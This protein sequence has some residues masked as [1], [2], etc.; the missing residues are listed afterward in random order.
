MSNEKE[1]SES[2][3]VVQDVP[4]T[5]N[6]G[7]WTAAWTVTVEKMSGAE[8]VSWD[9]D[10]LVIQ[11]PEGCTKLRIHNNNTSRNVQVEMPPSETNAL[12]GNPYSDLPLSASENSDRERCRLIL[13]NGERCSRMAAYWVGTREDDAKHVCVHHVNDVLRQG[14]VI[15]HHPGGWPADASASPREEVPPMRVFIGDEEL[16]IIAEKSYCGPWQIDYASR[17]GPHVEG[18]LS[19]QGFFKVK[20][21]DAGDGSLVGKYVRIHVKDGKPDGH[22]VA[23][24]RDYCHEKYHSGGFYSFISEGAPLED[25]DPARGALSLFRLAVEEAQALVAE[26]SETRWAEQEVC[27]RKHH[28]KDGP[29]RGDYCHCDCERCRKQCAEGC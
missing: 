27:P 24:I 25:S 22:F 3:A 4:G 17:V 16:P 20:V 26:L 10:T 15:G 1:V 13:D 6:V 5:S 28:L 14:D 23:L 2:K 9:G 7:S 21:E 29:C 18:L 11:V 8:I 12:S 19:R